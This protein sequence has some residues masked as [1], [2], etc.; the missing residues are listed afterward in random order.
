MKLE[1]SQQIFENYLNIK[2][3]QNPSSKSRVAPCGRTD[4]HDEAHSRFSQF[5]ELAYKRLTWRTTA[6]RLYVVLYIS[7]VTD[8]QLS[9]C[10]FM[11]GTLHRERNNPV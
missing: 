5:C 10:F 2:L 9:I 7:Y 4:R 8:I 6:N 11:Q 3:H 1:L